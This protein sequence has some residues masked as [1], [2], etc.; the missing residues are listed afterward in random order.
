MQDYH[1][2]EPDSTESQGP[3][4]LKQLIS[5][6]DNSQISTNTLYY[7][8]D[9]KAWVA[10]HSN[11]TL[12]K[13]LFPERTVL[14][15]NKTRPSTEPLNK[16]EVAQEVISVEDMLAAAEGKT[17]E[18]KHLKKKQ[19]LA[20]KAAALSMP[21]L[22]AIMLLSAAG[23]LAGDYKAWLALFDEGD[24]GA[25]LRNPLWVVG[26]VDAFIAICLFLSVSEIFPL[27]RFRAMLG[28]G[29]F[30]YIYWAWNEPYALIASAGASLAMFI[31]T[32]TLNFYAMI[33]VGIVGI[34]GTGYL[35]AHLFIG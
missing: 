22:A 12:A 23:F 32:L 25:I 31:G 14:H 5:L 13:Q 33:A 20:E 4:T 7:D 2:R 1:L 3:Y 19:E 35:L 10:I 21:I 27:L 30:T 24:F 29:Y 8:D 26:L 11:E 18:T 15:L 16:P 34:G 6:A 28:L 17:E 9:Q